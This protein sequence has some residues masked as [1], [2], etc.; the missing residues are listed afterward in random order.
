VQA[1]PSCRTALAWAIA[2]CASSCGTSSKLVDHL[3]KHILPSL[4]SLE[5]R[6]IRPE[7]IARWQAERLA[8]GHGRVSVR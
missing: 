3:N 8:A 4:G 5:L 1:A 7:T 2:I 6:A